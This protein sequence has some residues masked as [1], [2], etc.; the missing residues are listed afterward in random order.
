MTDVQWVW[1]RRR[2]YVCTYT[3]DTKP[4]IGLPRWTYVNFRKPLLLSVCSVQ[5]I[6]TFIS[7]RFSSALR[8]QKRAAAPFREIEKSLNLSN[9]GVSRTVNALS[10][11]NRKGQD[12]FDLLEMVPD[13][14]E[15]RRFIVRLTQKGEAFKRQLD[16]A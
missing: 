12:G 3:D 16:L 10:D 13:P 15:G 6:S 8:P 14:A 1:Y 9:S 11:V 4:S 2:A 5:L 7:R